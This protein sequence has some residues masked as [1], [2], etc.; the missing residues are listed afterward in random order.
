VVTNSG[1]LNG[2]TDF[3]LDGWQEIEEHNGSGSPT[4]QYVYGYSDEPLVLDRN[5]GGPVQRQFYEQNALGSVYALTDNTGK[6]TEGYQYDAYGR[7]TVFDPGP[8]GIVDFGGDDVITQGGSSQVGNSYMYTA[9]RLDAETGLFYFRHRYLNT[10]QGRFISRDPLDE[11]NG[12]NLYE[13]AADSPLVETDPTGEKIQAKITLCRIAITVNITIYAKTKAVS[14]NI[15]WERMRKRIEESVAVNWNKNLGVDC[16]T[17]TFKAVVTANTEA[18]TAA[19]AGGD[20]QI[21][22]NDT[23]DFRSFVVGDSKGDNG[24][25]H[26]D[27]VV[28]VLKQNNLKCPMECARKH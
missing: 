17:V 21:E 4:Q 20:N 18:R 24:V 27:E 12:M 15:N 8:N 11:P 13:Y 5:L 28:D 22:I 26:R 1:A 9:Q 14:E 2:T 19:T 16:C 6:I 25:V 3:Y 23:K 10:E 7:Q